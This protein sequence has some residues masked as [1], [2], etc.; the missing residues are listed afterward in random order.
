MSRFQQDLQSLRDEV[1]KRLADIQPVMRLLGFLLPEESSRDARDIELRQW[2]TKRRLMRISGIP[3][4]KFPSLIEASTGGVVDAVSVATVSHEGCSRQFGLILTRHPGVNRED[5]A[6]A[7]EQV[8]QFSQEAGSVITTHDH[9][10]ERRSIAAW[11]EVCFQKAWGTKLLSSPRKWEIGD[12]TV[13]VGNWEIGVDD[14]FPAIVRAIDRLLE[15]RIDNDG[16]KPGRKRK[17][18]IPGWDEDQERDL[19]RK[20][21]TAFEYDPKLCLQDF[22]DDRGVNVSASLFENVLRWFRKQVKDGKASL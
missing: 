19:C 3:A 8:L 11:L 17:Y 14:L 21:I 13:P 7:C 5:A 20:W 9:A 2:F 4:G 10:T 6:H 16:E 15:P 22:L 12:S 1:I 18:T